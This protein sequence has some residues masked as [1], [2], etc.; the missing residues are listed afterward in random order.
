M[1]R[2]SRR[3]KARERARLA[4]IPQASQVVQDAAAQQAKPMPA[5]AQSALRTVT[6]TEDLASRYKYVI[7]ELKRIGII[8]GSII[9]V[10]IVL[11][12]VLPVVLS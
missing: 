4:R 10:I 9:V 8:A 12:F 3:A 11:S 7:P 5:R 2:K 6:K 1:G